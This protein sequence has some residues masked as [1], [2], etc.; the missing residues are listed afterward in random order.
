[1]TRGTSGAWVFQTGQLCT[2]SSTAG[3]RS[4]TPSWTGSGA[5]DS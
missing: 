3:A 1:M 2:G 4:P 5:R